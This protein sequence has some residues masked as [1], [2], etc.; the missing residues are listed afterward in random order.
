M[1]SV[2]FSLSTISW[3][4]FFSMKYSIFIFVLDDF[5]QTKTCSLKKWISNWHDFSVSWRIFF[6]RERNWTE[7]WREG[8][9]AIERERSLTAPLLSLTLGACA[10][11]TLSHWSKIVAQAQLVQS[12]VLLFSRGKMNLKN[13][14]S[15]KILIFIISKLVIFFCILGKFKLTW[16]V[17][18]VNQ[19]ALVLSLNVI[20][21]VSFLLSSWIAIGTFKSWRQTALVF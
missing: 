16:L 3:I 10:S 2:Y 18:N 6:L 12:H 1:L 13:L 20:L 5:F 19:F 7:S 9:R 15:T 11:A 21:N 14:Y 17:E 8:V 4:F